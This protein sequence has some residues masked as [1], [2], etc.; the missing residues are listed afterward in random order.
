MEKLRSKGLPP[1]PPTQDTQP[2]GTGLC[3]RE[4]IKGAGSNPCWAISG[5]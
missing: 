2:A 1:C 3:A 5:L 4:L